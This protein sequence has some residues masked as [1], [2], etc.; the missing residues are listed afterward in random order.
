MTGLYHLN[1]EGSGLN[2]PVL[3]TVGFAVNF[4][5]PLESAIAPKSSLPATAV[6]EAGTG[7]TLPPAWQEWWRPLALIALVLL[8]LEWLVYRRSRLFQLRSLIGRRSNA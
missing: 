5:D 6:T 8:V 2:A 4:S 1:F 7:A 3:D